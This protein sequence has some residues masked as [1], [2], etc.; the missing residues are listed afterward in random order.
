MLTYIYSKIKTGLIDFDYADDCCFHM[1][2]KRILL[3]LIKYIKEWSSQNGLF[4]NE[5]KCGIFKIAKRAGK[6]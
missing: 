5:D 6:H 4:V 2:T 1:Q 3:L